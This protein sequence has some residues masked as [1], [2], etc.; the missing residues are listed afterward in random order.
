MK[1]L[2][3]S[4]TALAS[5]KESWEAKKESYTLGVSIFLDQQ[6]AYNNY[7]QAEYTLISKQY[8]YIISQ[9]TVL[10]VIG[11]LNK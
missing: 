5:A 9:F 6:L 1:Q 8:G 4:K 7:L 11:A 3:V 2:D 10:S